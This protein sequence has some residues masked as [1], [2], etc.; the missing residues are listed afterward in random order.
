MSLLSANSDPYLLEA[1]LWSL[2]VGPYVS[3]VSNS[4][5]I[6]SQAGREYYLV[7]VFINL[8]PLLNL[9]LTPARASS[10]LRGNMIRLD[11]L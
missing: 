5:L 7:D 1:T 11:P 2:H 8:P 4:L 9:S 6:P 10:M 3:R